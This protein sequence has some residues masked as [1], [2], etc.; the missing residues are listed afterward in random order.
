MTG[1]NIVKRMYPEATKELLKE[2]IQVKSNKM[3]KIKISAIRINANFKIQ[4]IFMQAV[5]HNNALETPKTF[6]TLEIHRI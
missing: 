5:K 3:S 6:E 4:I 1:E 2:D